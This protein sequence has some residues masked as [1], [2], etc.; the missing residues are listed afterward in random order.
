M[1]MILSPLL[2]ANGVIGI[3]ILSKT[4]LF[5]PLL[6]FTIFEWLSQIIIFVFTL[7][8]KQN[9]LKFSKLLLVHLFI[10]F[11]LASTVTGIY[12]IDYLF[13]ETFPSTLQQD[14]RLKIALANLFI[15]SLIPKTAAAYSL[16]V[17]SVYSNIA[18]DIETGSEFEEPCSSS[19]S[20]S[21]KLDDSHTN[22]TIKSSNKEIKTDQLQS[23]GIVN[24]KLSKFLKKSNAKDN[25]LDTDNDTT[26]NM[27]F[28][29]LSMPNLP[30]RQPQILQS[31]S[32]VEGAW[33]NAEILKLINS[34]ALSDIHDVE[35]TSL[36]M[37]N[38]SKF[39]F[40]PLK[41]LANNTTQ[42]FLSTSIQHQA[43]TDEDYN[44]QML[45]ISEIP[46]NDGNFKVEEILQSNISENSLFIAKNRDI[47]HSAFQ[48]N[49]DNETHAYG[50]K[51]HLQISSNDYH[52]EQNV[53][54][55][56]LS[57]EIR[58]NDT[59]LRNQHSM[60]NMT[61]TKKRSSSLKRK[62]STFSRALRG[63]ISS[64]ALGISV[65]PRRSSNAIGISHGRTNSASTSTI[66]KSKSHS[67]LKKLMNLKDSISQIELNR[68]SFDECETPRDTDFDLHLAQALRNSPKKKQ[69]MK[70]ISSKHSISKFA[71]FSSLNNEKANMDCPF[72]I[73]NIEDESFDVSVD[74][75]EKINKYCNKLLSELSNPCEKRVFSGMDKSTMSNNSVPSGY[76]GEYD[77][78]KWKVIK[79]TV[80]AEIPTAQ[81]VIG[82]IMSSP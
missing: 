75:G 52:K 45:N 55:E 1:L 20:N 57:K 49:I 7:L 62:E 53:L 63:S 43:E 64:S 14:K 58:Q 77:K 25:S 82:D 66:S 8:A 60:P 41:D 15:I 31:N 81:F 76:Y 28:Q 42:P 27:F 50:N 22:T 12:W 79:R 59:H 16:L 29:N 6:L 68:T 10:F 17:N 34:T 69:S 72:D 24:A 13:L 74:S 21:T 4:R 33:E 19:L 40:P 32:H 71:S 26:P 11:T 47:K 78:E 5:I 18:E 3:I 65:K 23:L 2:F 36:S 48:K 9:R 37:I 35:N 38:N 39:H 46:N 44:I 56:E 80:G 67:P 73:S 70:S 51:T 30:L 61:V 54:V